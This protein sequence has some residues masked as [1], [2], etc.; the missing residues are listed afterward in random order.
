LSGTFLS[1]DPAAAEASKGLSFFEKRKLM[2]EGYARQRGLAAEYMRKNPGTG[3]A[4]ALVAI[5]EDPAYKGRTGSLFGG[6]KGGAV[7]KL[8]VPL[9]KT[10]LASKARANP[11]VQALINQPGL[12]I[13]RIMMG[14]GAFKRSVE[15]RVGGRDVVALEGG[16][17][18]E[19]VRGAK[20]FK[21]LSLKEIGQ[22]IRAKPGRFAGGLGLGALGLAGV[23]LGG[24]QL[25]Q[26][27]KQHYGEK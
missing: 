15:Q 22:Y 3:M 16:V 8:D 24:H 6:T 10:E 2:A 11:E 25:Y 21:P 23:G 12:D 20:K 27:A 19:F 17:G 13:D 18:P 7:V 14:E 26:A 9:W 1:F 5:R 4:E